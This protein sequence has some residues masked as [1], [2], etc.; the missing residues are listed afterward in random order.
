M[1]TPRRS[2]GLTL[3]C[4][5]VAYATLAIVLTFPLVLNLSSTIPHDLGDPLL[6]TA[7]LWW[8]AHVMPLT[9]RWWDGFAFFPA[10]GTL[11]FSDHRLGLSL[12]ASPLQWLGAS[13]V[14]AHNL[15]FLATFPLSALAAHALSFTLTKRHDASALCGLAYGFNP[16][17]IL[18]SAHLEL[19]A[20]FGM[21]L[22]LAALHLYRDTRRPAWLVAFTLAL[23]LQGL[24]SSYY[25]LFFCVFLGL[26]ILWFST[27]REWRATVA[28][29]LCCVCA[30]VALSPIAAGYSRIHDEYGF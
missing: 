17:R 27:W 2:S 7:V 5:F 23:I 13:V 12:I 26:W 21:P 8:N 1:L 10:P 16:V 11:A 28:I 15:T 20:A 9:R 22:A 24:C 14:T 4:A 30:A 6:S 19:Q 29:L 18:H 3:V 25:L